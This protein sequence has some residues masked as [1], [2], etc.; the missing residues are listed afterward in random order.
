MTNYN[1]SSLLGGF[2]SGSSSP[3]GSINFS[4]YNSIKNGSYKKLAKNYY[5][6]QSGQSSK[7]NKTTNK[8]ENIYT[9]GNSELTKMKTEAEELK[10]SVKNLGKEDLWKKK[11]GEYDVNKIMSA[12][13]D[14]A[15]DYNDVVSQNSKVSTRDVSQ[16]TGFMTSLTNTMSKA[17]SKVGVTVDADGKMSVNEDTFKKADMSDVKALF[18]GKYSYATQVESKASAISSAATRN[19]SLYSGNGAYSSFAASM[20]DFYA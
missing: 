9:K 2:S 19:T 1:I 13:K 14:F 15:D 10:T 20:M 5:S 11:N 7:T 17:L 18:Q 6:K 12:V 8:K 4:E 3:F 16:Q